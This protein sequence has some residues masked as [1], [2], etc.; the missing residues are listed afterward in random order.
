MLTVIY[1]DNHLLVVD[2]PSGILTQPS[3]TDQINLEDMAKAFVK[4]H[5]KKEGAVFLHAIHRIDKPVSGVVLFA[6]TSKALSRLQ[7]AQRE[8]KCVKRYLAIIE[9]TSLVPQATLEHYLMHDDYHATIV[10]ANH[11]Q[12]KKSRLHYTILKQENNFSY[13]QIELET[14]RYHQIRAQFSYIGCPL[15]GDTKYG[16][17]TFLGINQIALHHQELQ[18][19]H[20]TTKQ[21]MN[22]TSQPQFQFPP[23]F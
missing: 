14:G 9:G 21:M 7:A 12:G 2:K 16:A 1:H 23:Q 6:R 19:C 3:G 5:Y 17:K 8:R 10:E 20:P 13:L 18:I 22:F 11:P 4:M 15:V